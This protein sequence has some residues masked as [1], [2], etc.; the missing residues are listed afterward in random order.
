MSTINTRC[1][2][3]H[4]SCQGGNNSIYN[5][6]NNNNLRALL[7]LLYAGTMNYLMKQ[8]NEICSKRFMVSVQECQQ[9]MAVCAEGGCNIRV[10][11]LWR[12]G[13]NST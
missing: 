8:R 10:H 13:H 7:R 1:S 5:Q 2:H 12:L 11:S 3:C 6:K 9:F 4:I